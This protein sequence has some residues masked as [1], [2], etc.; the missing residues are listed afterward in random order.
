[1]ALVHLASDALE[2]TAHQ[3]SHF[4]YLPLEPGPARVQPGS[5]SCYL[6]LADLL[7]MGPLSNSTHVPSVL[8]SDRSQ[9]QLAMVWSR[10]PSWAQILMPAW[11]TRSEPCSASRLWRWQFSATAIISKISQ[12]SL[13]RICQWCHSHPHGW[14]WGLASCL[15]AYSHVCLHRASCRRAGSP[16][17]SMP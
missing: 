7:Q 16:P 11:L 17:L 9:Q 2:R 6:D 5:S 15:V 4:Q 12:K 10:W 8:V 14:R 1:M 13:D 3:V